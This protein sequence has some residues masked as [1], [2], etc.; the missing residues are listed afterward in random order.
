MNSLPIA[1]SSRAA[2]VEPRGQQRHVV[3]R[4]L[5]GRVGLH[6]DDFLLGLGKLRLRLL[7]RELLIGRIELHHHVVFL[8]R[9]AGLDQLD[10]AE[11]AADRRRDQRDRA[12]GAQ[13]AGRVNGEA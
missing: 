6:L 8:D 5:H 11:R 13:L 7:E 1:S 9:H 3:L 10:D 4:R 12:P 2:H